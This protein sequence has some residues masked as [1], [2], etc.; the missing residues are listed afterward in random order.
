MTETERDLGRRWFDEVWNKGRRDAIAEMMAPNIVIHDGSQELRGVE[1]F[2]PFFDRLQSSFSETHIDVEDII[3][4]GDKLCIRWRCKAKHTGA[5]LDIPPTGRM[6]DVT[7]VSIIRVAGSMFTESWQN[8]DMLG[9]LQQV[10]EERPAVT[11]IAS[12]AEVPA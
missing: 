6:I 7:G 10:K 1:A 3:A 12:S 2:Y 8:W 9:M 4:E 11:Y 5:G